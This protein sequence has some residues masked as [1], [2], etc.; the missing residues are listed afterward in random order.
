MFQGRIENKTSGRFDAALSATGHRCRSKRPRCSKSTSRKQ[1][2]RNTRVFAFPFPFTRQSLFLSRCLPSS[3][4]TGASAASTPP[5]RCA[6]L[7]WDKKSNRQRVCSSGAA[8]AS[9][10]LSARPKAAPPLVAK[11][12]SDAQ[13]IFPASS[14]GGH[15]GWGVSPATRG[16][17]RHKNQGTGRWTSS[18]RSDLLFLFSCPHSGSLRMSGRAGGAR[19][20][21]S[22]SLLFVGS[23][24]GGRLPRFSALVSFGASL[25]LPVGKGL[26]LALHVLGSARI[27]TRMFAKRR[28]NYFEN[29][30][31]PNIR[32]WPSQIFFAVFAQ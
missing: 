14:G 26:L 6:A 22:F 15:V 12:E 9:S 4:T 29:Q 28:R 10:S 13:N 30:S 17:N 21:S 1:P 20:G 24:G 18:V 31:L 27:F 3:R 16:P 7:H 19:G 25:Y 32:H 11:T 8:Q 2:G 5:S 23:G